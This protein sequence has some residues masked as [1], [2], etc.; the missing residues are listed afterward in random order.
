[1]IDERDDA[2]R[3]GRSGA[4][5]GLIGRDTPLAVE[6]PRDVIAARPRSAQTNTSV[7]ETQGDEA[8]GAAGA[9]FCTRRLT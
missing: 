1:M 3:V 4:A 8:P 9:A 5:D 2:W 6:A 7:L